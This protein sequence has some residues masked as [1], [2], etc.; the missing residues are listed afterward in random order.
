MASSR[1]KSDSVRMSKVDLRKRRVAISRERR[2]ARRRL[3]LAMYHDRIKT[4]QSTYQGTLHAALLL[5]LWF[6]R[7]ASLLRVRHASCISCDPTVLAF[8]QGPEEPPRHTEP[9]PRGRPRR[10]SESANL[11]GL[12]DVYA[13]ALCLFDSELHQSTQHKL[14]PRPLHHSITPSLHHAITLIADSSSIT[15]HFSKGGVL[16]PGSPQIL[17]TPRT[18]SVQ[19]Q[20]E[21]AAT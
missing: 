7:R 1:A 15:A 18:A 8:C 4:G 2:G 10:F 14:S 12:S 5:L 17:A 19:W 3:P 20:A 11:C 13:K 9:R 16:T 21:P 6:V